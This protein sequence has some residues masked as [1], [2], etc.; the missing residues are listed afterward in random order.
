MVEEKRY[1]DADALADVIRSMAIPSGSG[2][3]NGQLEPIISQMINT[4][5]YSAF[6]DFRESLIQAITSAARPYNAC[7]LC[8]QRDCDVVPDH[9]LGDNR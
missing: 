3:Y 7:M 8:I 4:S 5:L 6:V 1:V 9:P 2:Y